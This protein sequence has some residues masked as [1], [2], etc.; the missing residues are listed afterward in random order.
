VLVVVAHQDDDLLF[1]NPALMRHIRAGGAVHTIYLTAGD[2]GLM[3]W[4]DGYLSLSPPG[5]LAYHWQLRE[6]GIR[7]AYAAMARVQ[8]TWIASASD[9]GAR[10]SLRDAP[11]VSVEFLRL[12]DGNMD[13]SGFAG[14]CHTSLAHL[15]SGDLRAFHDVAAKHDC[16]DV[17]TGSAMDRAALLQRLAGAMKDASVDEVWTLDATGKSGRDHSDHLTT[18]RFAQEAHRAAGSPK[19]L[20]MFRGYNIE[21]E[22]PN[23]SADEHR[24]K[25]EIFMTYTPYDMCKYPRPVA[26][27]VRADAATC[28]HDM[29]DAY[30]NWQWR[31]F[32]VS[33]GSTP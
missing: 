30:T 21:R 15:F 7:A 20:R 24:E 10:F 33:A 27:S 12:P 19:R 25:Q 17:G 14:T 23:L 8:D 18:A 9:R 4:S 16:A 13:G 28:D 5:V 1:M 26:P 6:N 22:A 32:E 11:Q 31:Q 29:G 2:A 3:H